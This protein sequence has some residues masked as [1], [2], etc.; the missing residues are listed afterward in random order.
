MELLGKVGVDLGTLLA[1]IINFLALVLI[2][3]FVLYRPIVKIFEERNLKV[4]KLEDDLVDVEKKKKDAVEEARRI[5]NH[6]EKVSQDILERGRKVALQFKEDR[7]NITEKEI[8]RMIEESH[9]RI[10]S[11]E[12]DIKKQLAESVAKGSAYAVSGILRELGFEKVLHEKLVD[13]CRDQLPAIFE[14]SFTGIKSG[15][16]EISS[17]LPL[18]RKDINYFDGFLKKKTGLEGGAVYVSDPSLIAGIVLKFESGHAVDF[19]FSG[20]LEKGLGN[21]F[22]E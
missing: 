10:L 20:R 6:S 12:S 11:E 5:I 14:E 7:L 13:L 4:K 9:L 8:D 3:R 19:S 16:A 2:L 22:S 17:P 1:Q 15:K 21:G 18:S